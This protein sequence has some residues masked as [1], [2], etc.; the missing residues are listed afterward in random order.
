MEGC[1]NYARYQA[2]SC[3]RNTV[4]NLHSRNNQVNGH[5]LWVS[6]YFKRFVCL[7]SQ[8]YIVDVTTPNLHIRKLGLRNYTTYKATEPV[9]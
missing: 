3:L 2:V 9:N 1:Q 4:K 7:L 6:H 5:L 8:L